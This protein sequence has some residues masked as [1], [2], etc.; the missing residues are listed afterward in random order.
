MA[1][2]FCST[3]GVLPI[4][5]VAIATLFTHSAIAQA[6]EPTAAA[7]G[8][9]ETDPGTANGEKPDFSVL[10]RVRPDFLAPVPVVQPKRTDDALLG[11]RH[12]KPD[13]SAAVTVGRRLTTDWETKIG[14]DL[15]LAAP[16]TTTPQPDTYLQGWSRQD[17]SSGAGW[18]ALAVPGVNSPIGWDKA[19]V[20]ARIDPTQNQSK[21]ATS[22]SRSVP[23]GDAT[24]LT[25][26]NG[27][28]VTET[29]ANPDIPIPAA[30]PGAPLPGGRAQ[31]LTSE[32][33]LS[34]SVF[35]TTLSAG[36]KTSSSDD[37]WLH[38]LSAEQKLFGGPLSI[39]GTISERLTGDLDKSIKAG[40][41]HTW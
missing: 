27:Y 37:R 1:W 26:Q 25:I 40:F 3:C 20:E 9:L 28:S 39:T 21:I 29:L 10:D 24:K 6:D 19:A 38:S 16:L 11:K 35:E 34:V 14:V 32:E 17:R 22:V 18:A 31:N 5:T 4:A 15:G 41:K 30:S 23:I 36:A 7:L 2:R 33:R 8:K 13:G 12:D